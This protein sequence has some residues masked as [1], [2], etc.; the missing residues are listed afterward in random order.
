MANEKSTTHDRTPK[1]DAELRATFVKTASKR[2]T[3]AVR[4]LANVAKLPQKGRK[5]GDAEKIVAALE[6]ALTT[7]KAHLAAGT[8]AEPEFT[9]E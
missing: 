9:L 1:T 3:T 8:T 2:T 4:A 5:A 6:K 7:T